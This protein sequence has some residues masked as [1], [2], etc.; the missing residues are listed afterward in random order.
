MNILKSK[1]EV[2]D[3]YYAAIEDLTP[4]MVVGK[5]IYDTKNP[6]IPWISKGAK[7]SQLI[8]DKLK[9]KKI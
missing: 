2:N 8:I 7:L 4:G 9:E 5:N 6:N 1:I 3:M